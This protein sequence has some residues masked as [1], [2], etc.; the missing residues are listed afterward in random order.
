[1]LTRT[2]PLEQVMAIG[3]EQEDGMAPTGRTQ[4]KT[5][6]VLGGMSD[7]ATAEYYRL[8]NE[9]VNTRCGG[10]NTAEVIISSVNFAHI[11]RFVRTRAWEKSGVY[12]GAKAQGLQRAGADFLICAS[13]TMHRVADAFTAGLSIPFL[14]IVDPTAEAIGSAGLRRVGLL[15][16]KPVMEAAYLKDRF[17]QRF[18]IEVIV[19][20]EDEQVLVDRIIFDELVRRTLR[21]ESRAIYLDIVDKLRARGAQGVV[22][23]CTEIVLLISQPDRPDFP[24]FDTTALHVQRAVEMAFEG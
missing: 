16:T 14:H 7:Q 4:Y 1:M 8:L 19:P 11:E 12:L 6:G 20:E 13:N 24:M 5:I 22:L 17:A 2:I 23:G 9:A 3:S 10:W 15:G 21:R 18:G